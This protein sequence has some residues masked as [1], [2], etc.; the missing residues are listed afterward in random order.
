MKWVMDTE[1][2]RPRTQSRKG[3]TEAVRNFTLA[4]LVLG[5]GIFMASVAKSDSDVERN[6]ATPQT[7]SVS[8]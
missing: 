4:F 7:K 3:F 6:L 2:Q 1:L 5:F 8:P